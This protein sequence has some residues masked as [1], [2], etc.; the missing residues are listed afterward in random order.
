MGGGFALLLAAGR[1]YNASSVNYGGLPKDAEKYLAHACPIVASY[2]A[3]DPTLRRAPDQLEQ[4]LSAH[5]I[6][7]DVKVYPEAGHGFLNDHL[8]S[9]TPRWALVM[10]ALSRTACHE[11]S[12]LDARARIVHFF[13]RHLMD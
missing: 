3:K 8:R 12:A 11:P 1:G 2:G 13:S 7:H 10:G 6:P 9:E 4:A 5:G